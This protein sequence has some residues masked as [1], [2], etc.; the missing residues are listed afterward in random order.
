MSVYVCACAC[1]VPIG[2]SEMDGRK[3][4]HG[5]W[6]LHLCFAFHRLF[7]LLPGLSEA[8]DRH[9]DFCAY[10]RS[11]STDTALGALS[12]KRLL[13][14]RT[15]TSSIQICLERCLSI[16]MHARPHSM[17]LPCLSQFHLMSDIQ[18]LLGDKNL[19]FT[20]SPFVMSF[21]LC[22]IFSCFT[23]VIPCIRVKYTFRITFTQTFCISIFPVA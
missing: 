20:L 12:W 6:S 7:H 17:L 18:F 8:E 10:P 3:E 23:Q 1:S 16:L 21:F 13:E 19:Y 14:H 15:M 2:N 9:Q 4:D 22:P 11:T 5:S